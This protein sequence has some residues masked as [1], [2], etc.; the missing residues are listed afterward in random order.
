MPCVSIVTYCQI[1]HGHVAG[2][3]GGLVL[4]C[5]WMLVLRL[6]CGLMVWITVWL[7]NL[8]FIACTIFC[9][10]KAGDISASSKLG[11][12]SPLQTGQS[13]TYV[14]LAEVARRK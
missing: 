1:E 14:H 8:S 13:A 7:A 11:Q 5:I 10:A 3:G 12:V 2:L 6:F 4:S 9:Y